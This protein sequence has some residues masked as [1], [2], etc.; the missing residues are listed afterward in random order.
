MLLE[1]P[2]PLRDGCLTNPSCRQWPLSVSDFCFY[3]FRLMWILN[4][5]FFTS[6]L[7]GRLTL[8][9]RRHASPFILGLSFYSFPRSILLLF[10]TLWTLVIE[11]SWSIVMS[12]VTQ[13]CPE[14]V[15]MLWVLFTVSRPITITVCWNPF[16]PC[17][18]TFDGFVFCF[19]VFM[20]CVVIY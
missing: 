7:L 9:S 4:I 18:S 8:Y 5:A 3:K 15:L 11:F 2:L 13:S 17:F 12:L 10:R 19:S 6:F 14:N 20:W 1:T 16:C